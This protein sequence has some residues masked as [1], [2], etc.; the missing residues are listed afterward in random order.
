M[1]FGLDFGALAG[2]IASGA[3]SAKAAREATQKQIE[4]E[5][6]RATH[7]HQWEVED[8]KKAGLNP[9]LSAG[10]QGAV[11]GS[12]STAMPDYSGIAGISTSSSAAKQAE[13]AKKG[14]EAQEKVQE[15]LVKQ[16][17]AQTA[18]LESQ[19]THSALENKRLGAQLEAEIPQYKLE[20]NY[21][22]SNIGKGLSY[23]GMG[24]RDVAPMLNLLSFGL[25]G[26]AAR[27]VI[28][29]A[30][31][32]LKTGQGLK[33]IKQLP[34]EGKLITGDKGKLITGERSYRSSRLT[35]IEKWEIIPAR[36]WRPKN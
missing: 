18:L 8:L 24:T 2:G 6:E 14:Q 17:K 19:T 20:K 10:G 7:A 31:S 32:A 1:A 27:H 33:A 25:G 35:P 23:V 28:K 29:G 13:T 4:W 5:R 36:Y 30:T 15:E 11:T 21:R 9:I 3:M 22:T 34:P 16:A 26:I 12:I